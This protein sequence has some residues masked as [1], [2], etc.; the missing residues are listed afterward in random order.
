M[1]IAK[2]DGAVGMIRSFVCERFVFVSMCICVCNSG[3]HFCNF[4]I[5]CCNTLHTYV[6]NHQS[7]RGMGFCWMGRPRKQVPKKEKQAN[8]RVQLSANFE[9]KSGILLSAI[10]TLTKK[11]STITNWYFVKVH[12]LARASCIRRQPCTMESVVIISVFFLFY[13]YEI[14]L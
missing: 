1:W 11:I 12:W 2:S 14:L 6:L 4:S 9:N 8:W 7:L 3:E 10:A 5:F 13:S